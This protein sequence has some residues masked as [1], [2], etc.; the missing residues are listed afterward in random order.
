MSDNRTLIEKITQLESE[1]ETLPV[2]HLKIVYKNDAGEEITEL[3]TAQEYLAVKEEAEV[4]S[5]NLS[6]AEKAN[7]RRSRSNSVRSRSSTGN[8]QSTIV[9]GNF[10]EEYYRTVNNERSRGSRGS[11]GSSSA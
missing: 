5:H 9:T 10:F 4:F 3:I 7:L 1:R 2:E 6:E 8:L 11:R